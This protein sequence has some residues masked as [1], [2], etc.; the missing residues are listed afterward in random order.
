MHLRDPVGALERLAGVL[1]PGGELRLLEPVAVAETLLHPRRPVAR[2]EPPAT[3]FNWWRPNA[4]AL[5]A[6]VEAAGLAEVR[7]IGRLHR[8]PA[9]REMRSRYSALSARRPA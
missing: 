3:D 8:P 5:E 4:A 2:F 1:A 6:W 9:L 7:R